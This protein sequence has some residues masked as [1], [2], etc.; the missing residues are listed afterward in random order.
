M[1]S[2]IKGENGIPVKHE[3][4]DVLSSEITEIKIEQLDDV[5]KSFIAI[6]SD[7][8]EDRDKDIIRT[9][10]WDL[11]NF[12]KNPVLP[13]GHNYYEPPVGKAIMIKRDLKKKQL[14]F[15]PQFDTNDEKA[16][17]IFNK[18]KNGFL[19]TFSVGFIGNEFKW[20]D[21]DNRWYGGRE[22]TK[23]ELLEISPVTIPSNPNASTEMRSIGGIVLPKNLAQEGYT[24]YFSRSESGLFYPVKDISLY[25][26]ANI[27]MIQEGV[28]AVTA[29]SL[30]DPE[31]K[32]GHVAG[33]I[34]DP[35]MFDDTSANEWVKANAPAKQ[36]KVFIDIGLND[37]G[38]FE[39]NTIEESVDTLR[40]DKSIEI[41][42]EENTDEESLEKDA[43]EDSVEKDADDS[44]GDSDSD[45]NS[46]DEIELD[47]DSE[48]GGSEDESGEEGSDESGEDELDSE[49]EEEEIDSDD[50]GKEYTCEISISIKDSKGKTIGNM[51]KTTTIENKD[52]AM[53]ALDTLNEIGALKSE[54]ESLKKKLAN[55]EKNLEN[56]ETE[57]E[58]LNDNDDI[59]FDESFL[60]ETPDDKDVS[61][62]SENNIEVPDNFLDDFGKELNKGIGSIVKSIYEEVLE[63]NSIKTK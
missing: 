24:D 37:S 5:N 28:K 6:A 52:D 18:Y 49:E 44:N 51:S 14:I 3:G 54:N 35:E 17:L 26:D 63:E 56:N 15:R 38:V 31:S 39:L 19:K 20:R 62:D 46:E 8:S 13:W 50:E 55:V 29:K 11:K 22:F 36:N 25:A 45:E 4:K 41:N 40:F 1:A 34:F 33:Y 10:G 61:D 23:Q 7:E 48:D 12:K 42:K 27:V 30:T 59:E 53:N 16:M 21:E 32:I 9:E 60:S 57:E 58:S 43:E 2:I 47:I